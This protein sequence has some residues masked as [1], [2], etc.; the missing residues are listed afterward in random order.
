MYLEAVTTCVNYSDF[1]SHAL[2]FNKRCFDRIVVV[3][4]PSDKQTQR[5][6]RFHHVECVETEEFGKGF[7]KARAINFALTNV[8]SKKGW[9]VHL[10]SDI[11]LPVRTRDLIESAELC[12]SAI[13]G[14][15]RM[16]CPSPEAWL[17]YISDGYP[18][19][20]NNVFV[21][22]TPFPIGARI[23]KHEYGGY[24]PIGFFQMWKG[25]E[26]PERLYPE[27]HE[28]AARTDMLFSLQWERKYRLLLPEVVGIHLGTKDQ[29]N[30]AN[31]NGRWTSPF[32][33]V[34]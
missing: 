34:E 22:C 11:V 19:Y 24:I 3:T 7:N 4:K 27:E 6:C 25:A 14:I 12:K 15:D 32:K 9:V 1:L 16:M 18:Q 17:N 13:Y 33:C 30:G 8:L 10:D 29:T 31:W 23:V 2:T 20:E 26:Y 28:N 5:V 21:H